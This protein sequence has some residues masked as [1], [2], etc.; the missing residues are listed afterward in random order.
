RQRALRT[1]ALASLLLVW[2]AI[3]GVGGQLVGRLSEVQQNNQAGFLPADAEST[4]VAARS[5]RFSGADT[6]PYSVLVER[7]Q[8]LT[9]AD[10]AAPGLHA[11]VTG[12]GGL[13]A[14]LVTAFGGIDGRLLGVALVAVFVI[15]LLV[16]RSPVLPF[17]ALLTAVLGLSAAALVVFPLARDGVIDL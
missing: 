11:Y 2:F 1:A 17:A 4:L 7:P 10:L 14:D 9:P 15:L 3:S 8:G 6:F 16:Y 12:P 13:T 5:A